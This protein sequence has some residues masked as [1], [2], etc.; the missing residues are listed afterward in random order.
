MS[1]GIDLAFGSP[2]TVSNTTL[3]LNQAIGGAGAAGST[4]GDGVGGGVNVGSGVIHGASDNCS[5]TLFDS[6]IIGN[7]AQCGTGGSGNNGGDGTGGGVS[8]TFTPTDTT[9]YSGATATAF[10]NVRPGP[11]PPTQPHRTETVVTAKPRS[12]NSGQ[13]IIS[14]ATVK[15][16]GQHCGV[17]STIPAPVAIPGAGR[18]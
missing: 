2:V 5:L 3:I 10:I 11:A 12:S 15:S 16:R 18:S 1:G 7:L 13:L 14:I 8:V 4:G 17:R 9:D 6:T